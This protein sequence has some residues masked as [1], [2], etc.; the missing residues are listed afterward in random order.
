L[1]F[2]PVVQPNSDADDDEHDQSV[3][4][5]VRGTPEYALHRGA[6]DVTG[7]P[8]DDRPD[9]AGDRFV[10]QELDGG[11][12]GDADDH[13]A[14]DAQSVEPLCDEDRGGTVALEHSDPFA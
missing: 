1:F 9:D 5:D 7:T 10:D 13:R 12:P 11:D 3:P 8:D 4:L 2:P 6:E 14:G